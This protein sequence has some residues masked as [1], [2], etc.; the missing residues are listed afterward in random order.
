MA[1]VLV[2]LSRV[3]SSVSVLVANTVEVASVEVSVSVVGSAVEI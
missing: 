3:V 1:A 2:A